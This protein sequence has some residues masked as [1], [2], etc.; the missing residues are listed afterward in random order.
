MRK[1]NTI[2]TVDLFNV[3]N[4]P[5]EVVRDVS[6]FLNKDYREYAHYVIETRALPSVIDGFKVGARKMMHAAFKGSMKM[7]Q[8]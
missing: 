6:D 7:E 2:T 1:K 4:T 3:D 5:K 8:K